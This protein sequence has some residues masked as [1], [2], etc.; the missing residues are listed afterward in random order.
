MSDQPLRAG[1][2]VVEPDAASAVERLSEGVYRTSSPEGT[3]A[4]GAVLGPL[5]VDGDLVILSG[6]LGAGK[7]NLTK[8]VAAALGVVEAVTSP[9]FNIQAIHEGT[10]LTLYH[11]DLYRMEDPEQLGDAGVLDVA[12]VEGASL[13]EWGEAFA[14]DLGDER[15]DVAIVR[16]PSANGV[17]PSRTFT[18]TPHGSRGPAL[19]ASFDTSVRT[20]LESL[21]D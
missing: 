16:D 9:T 1:E 17:E 18:L 8:G 14:D 13:V 21:H 4:L 2:A 19:L 20:L 12:G 3:W 15:L 5:L 6:D 10:G 7:T 11:F